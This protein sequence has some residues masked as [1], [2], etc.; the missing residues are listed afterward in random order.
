MPEKKESELDKSSH[1]IKSGSFVFITH[2]ENFNSIFL[3]DA[4]Y[5]V[6]DNFNTLNKQILKYYRKGWSNNI[7]YHTEI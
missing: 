2:F 1:P 7:Y 4:S 3:R 6:I 5:E